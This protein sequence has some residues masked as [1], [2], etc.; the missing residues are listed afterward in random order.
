L[1]SKAVEGMSFL[2]IEAGGKLVPPVRRQ[3]D[4]P[5]QALAAGLFQINTA[6][7][8]FK[9]LIRTLGTPEDTPALREKLYVHKPLL[10]FH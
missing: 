1:E 7:S 3:Q 10:A 9:R 6:L 5:S 4:D 8:S 2:D